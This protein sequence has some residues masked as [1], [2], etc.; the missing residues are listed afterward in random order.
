M[1]RKL[2]ESLSVDCVLF[3][4][5]MEKLN[6]LLVD[7]VLKDDNDT[8]IFS[9]LTLTGYHIY[10]DEDLN[11]AAARIVKDITGLEGLVL[12]QFHTFGSLT[13][14]QRPN[15]QLWSKQLGDAI[16]DRV[17]SVGYYSLLPNT[18]IEIIQKGRIVNWHP[19]SSVKNLA[20]DHEQI[21]KKALGHLRYKLQTEPIGF[22]LL[23]DKFTLTQMQ[24]LYETIIGVKF[25]KRNFRKK[26]SQMNYV[27]ALNEKQTGVAHKPAQLFMFSREVYEKTRKER[28]SFFT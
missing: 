21:L 1:E 7:R 18:D 17:V 25:D 26:I 6:V 3:G 2:A 20:Y 13:R 23:P 5:D 10:K 11:S 12:E 15:D 14:L 9:D 27:V 19:V 22:E 28:F 4:F 16:S 24:T 8:I